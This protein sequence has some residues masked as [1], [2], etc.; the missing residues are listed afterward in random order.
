ML[1]QIAKERVLLRQI[2]E[3]CNKTSQ[4]EVS[5]ITPT[6]KA[7]YINNIFTNYTRFNYPNRELI[8]ILNNN[9]L[10]IDDYKIKAQDLKNVQ[11]K[12]CIK[13]NVQI[14]V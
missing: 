4:P 13:N 8:I 12:V 3:K 9:N 2:R 7:K 10:N 14:K 1:E 11:V 5:I 6:N